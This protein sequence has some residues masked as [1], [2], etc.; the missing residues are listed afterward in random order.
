LLQNATYFDPSSMELI[1]KLLTL[2][3]IN[4]FV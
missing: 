2:A 1:K 3:K 4:L